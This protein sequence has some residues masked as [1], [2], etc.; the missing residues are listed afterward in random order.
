M[1]ADH[2][3]AGGAAEPY[4]RVLPR[5]RLQSGLAHE[6]R[7]SPVARSQRGFV[8]NRPRPSSPVWVTAAGGPVRG[9]VAIRRSV[10]PAAWPPHPPREGRLPPHRLG[11]A[12]HGFNPS[13]TKPGYPLRGRFPSPRNRPEGPNSH[14]TCCGGSAGQPAGRPSK[15]TPP[16]GPADPQKAGPAALLCGVHAGERSTTVS[17]RA[18]SLATGRFGR[19]L[20]VCH[21]HVGRHWRLLTTRRRI[22][23]G[24]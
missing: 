19:G 22:R 12:E 14:R 23:L 1:V 9:P 4:R 8:A 17:P 5:V 15:P 2:E 6:A 13:A 11:E 21:D 7:L 18:F 3:S 16:P 24:R 10:A 20:G